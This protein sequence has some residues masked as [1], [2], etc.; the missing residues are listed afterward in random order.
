MFIQSGGR[1]LVTFNNNFIHLTTVNKR[2]R[3]QVANSMVT[4]CMGLDCWAGIGAGRDPSPHK[5]SL[6]E[7]LPVATCVEC[8]V[9]KVIEQVSITIRLLLKKVIGNRDY[10]FFAGI[11]HHYCVSKSHIFGCK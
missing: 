11:A 4:W 8:Y 1:A 2:K 10:F 9:L 7:D 6:S 3:D 5:H